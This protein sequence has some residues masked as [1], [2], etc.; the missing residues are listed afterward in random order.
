MPA[1]QAGHPDEVNA[2]TDVDRR[3]RIHRLIGRGAMA[4]VYV[5]T[6]SRLDR[7]VALKIATAADPA[8]R[9]R[10]S[11]EIRALRNLAHPH[12][13]RLLDAGRWHDRDYLVLEHVDG[14][15]LAS[16]LRRGPLDIL[17]AARIATESASALAYLH[18]RGIV[19]RDVKPATI[20]LDQEGH[21]RLADFGTARILDVASR[22]TATGQVIGTASYLSP[23][24][25]RGDAVG[26]AS[27]VYSLGLVLLEALTGRREYSGS[28][29]EAAVARLT[30]PPV[31]GPG[32]PP[33]WK[34]RI[35]A[36]TAHDPDERPTAATVADWFGADV[37]AATVASRPDLTATLTLPFVAHDAPLTAVGGSVAVKNMFWR[38]VPRHVLIRGGIG[39]AAAA[40]T[41]TC[42]V[43]VAPTGS[44]GPSGQGSVESPATGATPA[45]SAVAPTA[46]APPEA[47][48]VAA[49]DATK[50]VPPKKSPA[51]DQATTKEKHHQNHHEHRGAP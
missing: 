38:R 33:S 42:A 25:V 39:A 21:A 50:P 17:D 10:A 5:A 28:L 15:S 19:H 13:V 7:T 23:E 12:V 34:T 26:P 40:V 14:P 36:M 29:V 1:L 3:Y 32:L 45:S 22:L 47:V 27:D 20:L 43:L 49:T 24:Q 2:D 35:E 11:H 4:E 48:P 44:A 41:A 31:I 30:R 46:A 18:E 8:I 37:G 9:D 16:R 51:H 6:D